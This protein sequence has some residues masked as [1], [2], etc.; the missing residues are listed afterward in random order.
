MSAGLELMGVD[1]PPSP[2]PKQAADATA[3]PRRW[4]YALGGIVVGAGAAS[5]A[6]WKR[7][8]VA[9][10]WRSALDKVGLGT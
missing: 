5:A 3:A 7:E 9:R 2:A 1:H 4:P 10:L 8:A 6:W